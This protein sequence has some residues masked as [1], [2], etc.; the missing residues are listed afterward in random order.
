MPIDI[1]NLLIGLFAAAL[2]LLGLAWQQHR[3]LSSLQA[4]LALLEERLANAQLAQDGLA[5]QLDD[6]R[7]ENRELGQL[8]AAQQAELAALRREA[9]LL[10][11]ERQ[12][13][14]EALQAWNE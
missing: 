6:S 1:P 3:R 9:E 10:G 4:E 5:V 12:S 14:R 7:E 2:P 8:N 11:V 13:A